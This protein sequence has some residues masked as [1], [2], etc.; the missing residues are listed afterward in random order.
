MFSIWTE[1]IRTLVSSAF[2]HLRLLNEASTCVN[3]SAVCKDVTRGPIGLRGNI[4]TKL[5]QISSVIRE[6]F[7]H[8]TNTCCATCLLRFS[9]G[10]PNVSSRKIFV[11]KTI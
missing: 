9:S 3:Q 8:L 5:Y 10:A 11:Q 2:I 6:F 1:I 4:S 7:G